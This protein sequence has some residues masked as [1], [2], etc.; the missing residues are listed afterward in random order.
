MSELSLE[1]WLMIITVE[2]ISRAAKMLIKEKVFI[3]FGKKRQI[4]NCN[5]IVKKIVVSKNEY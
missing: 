3:Q 5:D 1:F 4:N 2:T